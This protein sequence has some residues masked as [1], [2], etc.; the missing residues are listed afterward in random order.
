MDAAVN[1]FSQLLRI[2]ATF[3]L[4]RLLDDIPANVAD[5]LAER[6][7]K[8]AESFAETFSPE[9]TG[10]ERRPAGPSEEPAA[11]KANGGE[12]LCPKDAAA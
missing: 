9:K 6:V 12:S 11:E 5:D 1:V 8:D 4:D 10:E 7:R 2:D 3:N